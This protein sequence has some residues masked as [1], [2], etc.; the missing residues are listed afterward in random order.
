M[1]EIS[2]VSKMLAHLRARK[3]GDQKGVDIIYHTRPG[4]ESPLDVAEGFKIHSVQFFNKKGDAV[5]SSASDD[6][7]ALAEL[8]W[9]SRDISPVW[10]R[11]GCE[12]LLSDPRWGK[13]SRVRKIEVYE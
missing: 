5:A 11:V 6:D 3:K 10:V 8:G 12:D 9:S 4:R 1:R 2:E 13:R 7:I